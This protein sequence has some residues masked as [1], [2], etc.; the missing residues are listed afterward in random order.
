MGTAEVA[1]A[2]FAVGEVR[3]GDTHYEGGY[4]L[5]AL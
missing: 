5:S 1:V 4:Y 2:A 3:G